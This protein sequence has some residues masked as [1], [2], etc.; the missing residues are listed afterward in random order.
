MATTTDNYK[1]AVEI[2]KDRFGRDALRKE[3][4][5]AN[6]LRLQGVTNADD[7]K[8]LRRLI[9]DVTANVRSLEALD[10]STDSYGELLLPVLKGKIPES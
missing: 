1:I 7:L 5:I 6:L 2:L 10:T 8:S 9:D 3:T 4:L